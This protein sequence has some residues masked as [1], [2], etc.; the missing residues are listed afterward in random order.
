MFKRRDF[1]DSHDMPPGELD[2][3]LSDALAAANAAAAVMSV[4]SSSLAV[5]LHH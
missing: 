2:P 5:Q 1:T 4:P 3:Q